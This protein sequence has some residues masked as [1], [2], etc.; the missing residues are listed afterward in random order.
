MHFIG[1]LIVTA[2]ATAVAVWLVPGI[3]L[4]SSDL[5][6]K[7]L[8]LLGVALVFGAVNSVVAPL[9]KG[10]SAC[11]IALTLGI[12]LLVI[13]ALMLMLTSWLSGVLG[14]GFEVDGFWPALWGSIVI[15][16]IGALLG[17]LLGS[18]RKD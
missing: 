5:G 9:V 18:S 15:S 12:A 1:R 11:L 4:T 3:S 13:N 16:I 6:T 17:G 2:L 14:L 10:L 8:T 7:V